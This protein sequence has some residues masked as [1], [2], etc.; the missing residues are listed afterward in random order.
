MAMRIRGNYSV[1]NEIRSVDAKKIRVN[2]S[3]T[4][5]RFE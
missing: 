1:A 2:V 4:T 5:H 3:S